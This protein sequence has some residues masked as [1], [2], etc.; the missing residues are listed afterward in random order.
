[1][2][3]SVAES[4]Q[5]EEKGYEE[6]DEGEENILGAPIYMSDAEFEELEARYPSDERL[7]SYPGQFVWRE[8]NGVECFQETTD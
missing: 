6:T 2:A 1:M 8:T 7:L 4:E 3:Q 5:E